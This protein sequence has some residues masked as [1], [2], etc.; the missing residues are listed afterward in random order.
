MEILLILSIVL[1]IFSLGILWRNK[2][3]LKERLHIIDLISAA[4][5]ED[6]NRGDFNW[7]WRYNALD[8]ISYNYMVF[9]FWIPVKAFYY[10]HQCMGRSES[11]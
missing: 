9:H 8:E 7:R 11:N 2:L 10:K 5:Q 4:A 1:G 3:V 6:I